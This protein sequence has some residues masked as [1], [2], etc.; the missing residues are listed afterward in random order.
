MT[1]ASR[2]VVATAFGGPEGL[3]V[4]DLELP[5]PGPG[6][7]LVEVRA[8]GVNPID[9]KMYA[10]PG[11]P[12]ALP[13][14]LGFEASGVVA[15]VGEGVPDV[16]T[17]DEVIVSLGAAGAYASHLLVD[18]GV[19]TRKPADLGWPEAAGLLLTG[20]TAWHTLEATEVSASDTVLVHGGAGGVGLMAVQLA[21][22]RGA[23][24]IATA[25]EG[26]HD[27][28]R[29]LG[30]EPVVYG[31]GLVDRVRSLAPDGVDVSL[32]LVG[33]DEAVDVSLALVPDRSRIA[34]IAAFAR[35]SRE[36]IRLLGGP[37]E[38]GDDVRRAARP[39]LAKLAGDGRLRVLVAASYPLERAADAHRQIAT[40]HTTGK[41]ALLP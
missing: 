10:G 27:L 25:S 29:D 8:A 7:A 37:D 23:R 12:S 31:E 21:R 41:L 14:A 20:A 24:V 38:P 33:S 2:R 1:T 26:S 6:E 13:M 3:S 19:L 17:G 5:D 16:R 39:E 18:A 32:D 4:H 35:A 30:A 15:A 28:L 9:V 34:S 40:G 11:D 22:L 36:G